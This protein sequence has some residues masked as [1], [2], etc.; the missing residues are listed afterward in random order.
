MF[1]LLALARTRI[2]ASVRAVA[3]LR[4]TLFSARRPRLGAVMS[5]WGVA[6]V[7][8]VLGLSSVRGQTVSTFISTGLT[9]PVGLVFD[10]SGNL[11]V[12]HN[13]GAGN[14]TVLKF[15]TAGQSVATTFNSQNITGL[16]GIIFDSNRLLYWADASTAAVGGPNITKAFPAGL[17]IV[18]LPY[19]TTGLSSPTGLAYDTNGNLYVAN[20]GNGNISKYTSGGGLVSAA[21]NTTALTAPYGLAFDTNGNLYV[22]NTDSGVINKITSA[23]AVSTFYTFAA[24]NVPTGLAFDTSGNLYV[25]TSTS[26]TITQLSSTG[27]FQA[28]VAL[29]NGSAPKLLAFDTNGNLYVANYGN[30][31]VSKITPFPAFVAP[32]PAA[33][34]AAA[35]TVTTTPPVITSPLTYSSP[36]NQTFSYSIFASNGPTS[37]NATNVPP[38]CF[39][40]TYTGG[41]TGTPTIAGVYT[42]TISATNA[43][44]TG[45]ATLVVTIT[46]LSQTITFPA[47]ATMVANAAP[48]TL[49]ATS[50]SGLPITYT[51]LSGPATVSGNTVTLTGAAGTVTIQASQGGNL[52]YSA[53][54]NASVSFQVT[55]VPKPVLV[56]L[57]ARSVVTPTSPMTAGF[58]ISGTTSKTLVLRGVGPGLSSFGLG[59]SPLLARPQLTLMDVNGNVLATNAGWGGSTALTSAFATVGA[60]PLGSTSADS[61]LTATLAPGIYTMKLSDAA[62][63][64]GGLALAELYDASVDPTGATQKLI[65]LSSRGQVG[66]GNTVLVCGFMVSGTTA[67]TVLIRGVGPSLAPYGLT[68]LL[69]D[70]VLNVYDSSGNLVATNND[71]GTPVGV[72]ATQVTATAATLTST[73]AQVGAFPLIAGSKDAALIVTL[74]PGAYT[75][76]VSGN[77]GTTGNGMAEVY[78]IPQ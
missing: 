53:A 5:R 70:P 28:S 48:F 45:S 55:A 57:S 2:N 7:A 77:G 18:F 73:A 9:N 44:G 39:I 52:A 19:I 34:S 35:P 74:P 47:P 31:T 32:T 3:P 21:F 22:S 59:A 72:N 26:N 15:S 41:I 66:T 1:Q 43:G 30:N 37:Y 62:T 4:D 14:N 60:F 67:K 27:V 50:S 71:W 64:A 33:V 76:Q 75:A 23:G 36:A 25:A 29:P 42:E 8:A 40:N 16:G 63:D 54:S 58:I 65:N 6:A 61:A 10:T 38:G 13:P 17:T 12:T 68:G 11:Y 46:P 20:N 78:E 49:A 51:V 69:A 56:N 24:G